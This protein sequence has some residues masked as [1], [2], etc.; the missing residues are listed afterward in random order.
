MS[1]APETTAPRPASGAPTDVILHVRVLDNT[2]QWGI[3]VLGDDGSLGIR[4][5]EV[6]PQE[7]FTATRTEAVLAAFSAVL[8]VAADRQ[9]VVL[10]VSNIL[11]RKAIAGMIDCVPNVLLSETTAICGHRTAV[12]KALEEMPVSTEVR[13][14]PDARSLVVSTDASIANGGLVAGL[15]W[16]IAAEDGT[17]LS[18]GQKT[19]DVPRCGDILTGELLA[20]RWALQALISRHPVPA[21]CQGTVMVQSDSKAAL[22]LLR[23]V[24]AGRQ[25]SAFTTDQIKLAKR[26]LEETA[27]MPVGFRWVK[28]HRGDE[29]NE[30]ADRLAVLARRNREFGVATDVGTRMFRDLRDELV[31]A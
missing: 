29:G 3:G 22:R 25:P 4:T 1:A 23:I 14:N 9:Y 19:A 12:V 17:V 26:I 8:E 7:S 20:I 15:G 6:P 5:G 21:E 18:C 11:V 2:G 16:V 27:H 31:A 28:G 13:L 24:A 30:A 10:D